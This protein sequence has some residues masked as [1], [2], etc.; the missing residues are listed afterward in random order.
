MLLWGAI[1]D[2]TID[3]TSPRGIEEVKNIML[4]EG[5]GA[6]RCMFYISIADGERGG[7]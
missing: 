7:D 2:S 4:P 6:I 3:Q 1:R 5:Y